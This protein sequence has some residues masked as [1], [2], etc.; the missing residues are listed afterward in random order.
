MQQYLGLCFGSIVGFLSLFDVARS[1]RAAN[2]LAE[3]DLKS[4]TNTK[5]RT[6]S[7]VKKDRILVFVD[8]V[9]TLMSQWFVLVN[10][11][12]IIT[13]LNLSHWSSEETSALLCAFLFLLCE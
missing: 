7:I 1:A 8:V 13:A 11:E 6:S 3:D 12:K 9:L 5:H 2:T 10:E 4:I